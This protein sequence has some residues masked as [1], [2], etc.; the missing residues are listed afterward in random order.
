[1]GGQQQA[2]PSVHFQGYVIVTAS[3]LNIRDAP[4]T[5]AAITADR[6]SVLTGTIL[7]VY[8]QKDGWL[9]ISNSQSH[10]VAGRFTH[11][12]K[13]AV[14]RADVLRVRSGPQ[15]TFTMVGTVGK[16]EEIFVVEERDGWSKISLEDR[17][18]SS[19]FL[20]FM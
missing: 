7:R 11:P 12:V 8:E 4:S 2:P 20:D 3:R 6:E 14:V 13:L 15:N 16:G 17:W 9:K 1:M 18:V 19:G 10:W 5:T